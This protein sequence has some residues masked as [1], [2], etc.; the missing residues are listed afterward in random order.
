MLSCPAMTTMT[1]FLLLFACSDDDDG[2]GGDGNHVDVPVDTGPFNTGDADADTDADTDTDTD[3]DSGDTA[4][5]TA[6]TADTG[7]DIEGTGYDSG[8]VAYNFKAP[9]QSDDIWALWKQYGTVVILTFGDGADPQ[10]QEISGWAQGVADKYGAVAA[11]VL[12]TDGSSTQADVDDAVGWAATYGLDTVLYKPLDGS[13]STA[14][15][16]SVPP[17]TYVID[18]NMV[19][20]WT[21]RGNTE[22]G[23]VEDKVKDLVLGK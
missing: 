20:D 5:D 6:D 16:A 12:L 8:D 19:I 4:L 1:L 13:V 21:N 9:N 15:W 10:F 11:T 14:S 3:T 7:L 22:E 23:Q 2:F 17:M 18:Q